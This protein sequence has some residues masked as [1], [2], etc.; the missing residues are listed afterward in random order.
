MA[1]APNAND[2]I[3]AA[4]LAAAQRMEAYEAAVAGSAEWHSQPLAVVAVQVPGGGGL[5]R[6]VARV[7]LETAHAAAPDAATLTALVLDCGVETRLRQVTVRLGG[8]VL[9]E[10]TRAQLR[11]AA[12]AGPVNLLAG[13]GL[14][15][16][17]LTPYHTISV[18]YA[19]AHAADAG[20][21]AH[22]PDLT[23][24]YGSASAAYVAAEAGGGPGAE[25][26]LKCD[27]AAPNVLRAKH[28][29]FCICFP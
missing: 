11:E 25:L 1:A 20:E 2:F 4:A 23:L 15:F 13:R 22:C 12:E 7:S 28:G 9:L 17:P 26:P 6:T 19:W 21:E 14:P 29:L 10:W 18:E 5:W 24:Q 8:S 16:L 3:D 27:G